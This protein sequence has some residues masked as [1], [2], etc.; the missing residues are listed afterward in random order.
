M[1]KLFAVLGMLANAGKDTVF[2]VAAGEEAARPGSGSITLFY[3]LKGGMIAVLA[4]LIL[5]VIFFVLTA[6]QASEITLVI[7]ISQLSFLFTALLAFLFLKE[8]MNLMKAAGILMAVV[9]IAVIG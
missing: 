2:K 1:E 6:L 4:F 7:P 9:S 8:K 3:A 5:V